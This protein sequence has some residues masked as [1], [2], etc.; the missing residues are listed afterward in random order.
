M[1]EIRN[2]TAGYADK[3]VLAGV[4]LTVPEGKTTILVG[5]NG[6]GKT[7]L[8]KAV[9]GLIPP[10]AGEIIMDGQSLISLSPGER[11]RKVACLPQSRRLPDS[12]A[13]QLVLSGRFPYLAWPRRYGE[14]DREMARAAMEKTGVWPLKEKPVAELSGG[15]RQKVYIAMALAQDTPL[16]LMDEPTTFLDI[17]HQLQ[18]MEQARILSREGKAVLMVLHD[19]DMALR[20]ADQLAVMKEGTLIGAGTPE[21]MY[22][23]GRLAEAFHVDVGRVWTDDGWRYY[24]RSGKGAAE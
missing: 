22:E 21:E 13:F 11:A 19:L 17:A 8:L 18:T 12:T 20:Y 1:L 14:K 16:I 9:S 6:C 4:S 10:R 15:M 2:L 24:Y 7:T 23:S 5:P 3:N